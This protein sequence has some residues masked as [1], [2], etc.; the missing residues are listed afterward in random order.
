MRSAQRVKCRGPVF[1]AGVLPLRAV[2]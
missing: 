1:I 2:G